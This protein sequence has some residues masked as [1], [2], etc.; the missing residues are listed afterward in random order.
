[1]K[2]KNTAVK[3]IFL[4]GFFPEISRILEN[5]PWGKISRIFRNFPKFSGNFPGIFPGNF[6]DFGQGGKQKYSR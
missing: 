5:V 6:P 1:V 3:L 2:S 4:E